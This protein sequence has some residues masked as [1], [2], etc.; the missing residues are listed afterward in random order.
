VM[1]QEG[2]IEGAAAAGLQG[3]RP[4]G[5]LRTLTRDQARDIVIPALGGAWI[6]SGVPK[7]TDY[8]VVGADAGSKSD[9]SKRL[10]AFHARRRRPFPQAGGPSMRALKVALV[11]GMRCVR[12]PPRRRRTSRPPTREQARADFAKPETRVP[13]SSGDPARLCC[14]DG[15]TPPALRSRVR[16]PD[17][18]VL[19]LAERVGVAGVEPR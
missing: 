15:L 16:D 3:H 6:V 11:L 2:A 1:K 17:Y 7:K 4:D 9:D 12:S 19:A 10:G 13:A 5:G 14:L 8:V 18:A